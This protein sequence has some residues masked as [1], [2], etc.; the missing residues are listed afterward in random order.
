MK[1]KIT[2]VLPLLAAT[3]AAAA[4]LAGCSGKTGNTAPVVE[5][6][7]TVTSELQDPNETNTTNEADS[8]T[9]AA[10]E[11]ADGFNAITAA[12]LPGGESGFTTFME[13]FCWLSEDF[14]C[15]D[16]SL[17]QEIVQFM[18]C[19]P[20]IFCDFDLYTDYITV[21]AGATDYYQYDGAGVDWVLSNIY[22]FSD[23]DLTAFK[24]QLSQL[25]PNPDEIHLLYKDGEYW[26]TPG[27]VG[28][29]AKIE[30]KEV[31]TDGEQYRITYDVYWSNF[32]AEEDPW[33]YDSTHCALMEYKTIDGKNYWSVYTDNLVQ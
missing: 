9:E 12:E 8:T 5:P 17:L 26:A 29:E 1:R 3:T 25:E 13:H 10:S 30:I 28:G 2:I 14:D 4:L 32:G 22:N 20:N 31:L 23:D 19:C 27:G 18:L 21:P 6:T 11:A 16:A 7:S 15:K 24:N 33:D